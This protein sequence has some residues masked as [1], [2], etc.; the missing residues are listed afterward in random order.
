MPEGEQY[1]HKSLP[2]IL[3]NYQPTAMPYLIFY[4]DDEFGIFGIAEIIELH[5]SCSTEAQKRLLQVLK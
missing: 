5:P 2:V 1:S 4:S 3:K